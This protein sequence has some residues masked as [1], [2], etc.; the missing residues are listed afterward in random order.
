[1]RRHLKS[2]LGWLVLASGL[3]RFCF[4]NRAVIA[5]FHRV[6]DALENDPI[7]CSRGTFR[8]YCDLF[9]RYFVGTSLQELIDRLRRGDDI[10]GRV[11]IT[12]DDGYRDNSEVA[13]VELKRRGLP[14]CFFLATGYIGTDRVASW[15][16]NH[17]VRSRWMGWDDVRRLRQQGFEFGAH[18][19]SHCD[20]GRVDRNEA[21]RELT[22]SRAQLEQEL[23]EPVR[24]FSYPY[25]GRDNITVE[26]QDEVRK[27]GFVCCLSAF[28]GVVARHSDPFHLERLPVSRWHVSPY[29][30]I[31]EAMLER[32][33]ASRQAFS[34]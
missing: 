26:N 30:F 5:V 1:M 27:A 34:D 33:E 3:Y 24:L 20:L 11:V 29:Q 23:G 12:F 25:G 16:R 9:Q 19:I 8:A 2:L 32:P 6:D 7:S 15:D 22:G 14:A 21:A 17:G 18:T 10:G 31:F 13:A 28:G 4:R